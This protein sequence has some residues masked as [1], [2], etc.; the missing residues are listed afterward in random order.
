MTI[1]CLPINRGS[2]SVVSSG[3]E[4]DFGVRLSV[5]DRR[6]LSPLRRWPSRGQRHIAHRASKFGWWCPPLKG[7]PVGLSI[8]TKDVSVTVPPQLS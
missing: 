7:Y 5:A 6:T 3:S 1:F 4:V 2:N 8:L